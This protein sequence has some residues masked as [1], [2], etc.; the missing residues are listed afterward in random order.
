MDLTAQIHP[1]KIR[2]VLFLAVV[3]LLGIVLYKEMHFMLGAFLGAVA[4]YMLMRKL[5]YRLT[6]ERRWKPWI[7]ALIMMLASLIVIVLPFAWVITVLVNK[8]SPYIANPAPIVAAV[9]KI[10]VFVKAKFNFEMTS[11]ENVGK[12]TTMITNFVPKILGGT[13]TT[14][15]NVIIM[16][17]I[18]YFLLVNASAVE[19]WLRRNL[20]FHHENR[21]KVLLEVREMVKSNTIGIP[22]MAVLQGIIA[23]VGFLIFNVNEPLLWGIITGLCSVIP[24]VGTII[25]WGPIAILAFANGE[26]GNGIGITLWG[27]I[28]IGSSDNVLRFMMQKRMSNVHPLITVFGVIVG[29]NM[30][31]FLGLIFGPLLISIFLLLVK[32]YIDE[33]TSK[34]VEVKGQAES[35]GADKTAEPGAGQ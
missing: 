35:G 20:P 34:Q 19:M 6:Y 11:G 24:F 30:F 8:L 16:Y 13:L 28:F 3:I 18:L 26:S 27:L 5:M 7:S 17:F 25:A 29:L 22:L 33:F 31:G 2:Q 21:T 12:L 15:T 1:N 14:L 10:D 9:N 23:F 4:L 32:I